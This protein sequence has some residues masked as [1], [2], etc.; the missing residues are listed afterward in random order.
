MR[1]KQPEKKIIHLD[2][3][4]FKQ[5]LLDNIKSNPKQIGNKNV[6]MCLPETK[7]KKRIRLKK[8]L[9]KGYNY[10]VLRPLDIN[11]SEIHIHWV[12]EKIIKGVIIGGKFELVQR[13]E[14]IIQK[15]TKFEWIFN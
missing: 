1:I 3:Y 13:K 11:D 2:I 7:T 9:E 5:E 8:Y 6:V 4:A 12:F 14:K 10:F 15:Q